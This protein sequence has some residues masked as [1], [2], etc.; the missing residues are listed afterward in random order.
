MEDREEAYII[1]DLRIGAQEGS[2]VYAKMSLAELE[3][4][5]WASDLLAALTRSHTTVHEGDP[6][7]AFE[8][9]EAV[10]CPGHIDL[11]RCMPCEHMLQ[12]PRSTVCGKEL[13][14]GIIH[15]SAVEPA[16]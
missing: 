3:G 4:Q 15:T 6:V 10:R 16:E 7:Q 8:P 9:K 13:Q 11:R 12:S 1:F 2:R 14:P 5:L